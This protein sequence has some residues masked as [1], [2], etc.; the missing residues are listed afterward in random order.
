M[1]KHD[2]QGK[3]VQLDTGGREALQLQLIKVE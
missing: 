2:G 1:K 3:R